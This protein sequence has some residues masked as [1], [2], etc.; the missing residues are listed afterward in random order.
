MFSS[1]AAGTYYPA[2]GDGSGS[3]TFSAAANFGQR[4]FA[5]TPPAGFKSLNTYNLPDSTIEDGGQYFNT[6]T[7]TG[8]GSTQS[9]T[10][11][12]FQ[13][14]WVWAK[15]RSTAN[16]HVLVDAVR[17]NGYFLRSNTTDGDAAV[18]LLSS[19]DSD[20]FS[21]AGG[22]SAVNSSGGT[23]VAWNWK[24]N[25]SGVSNTDGSIT[26]TVS[27]N[28]TAG[29]SIVTYTTLASIAGTVGHGL[30][31]VPDM[32]IAKSRTSSAAWNVWHKDILISQRLRLD[33]TSA[34]TSSTVWN[35]TLPTADVFTQNISSTVQDAVAY[36][37]A[38]VEGFSKFGSYTGNG[39]TDGPFIH[40]GFRPAWVMFKRTD[41]TGSWRVQDAARNTYNYVNKF[42][43]ANTSDAEGTAAGDFL[44]FTSNGIKLRATAT[45]WNA[46]GGTYIYMAFA[47]SPFKLSLAR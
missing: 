46:S 21:I 29:F 4:P 9:I 31:V 40:L 33:D 34:A 23:Y 8:N 19:F 43:N 14:D 11:V 3:A 32:V 38:D 28:T 12:G 35:S 44:D 20:G 36:C 27:A 26:S 22:Y 1:I 42:L 25:G 5:Y 24:A 30:G 16:Y 10:G 39:S 7:Y 15:S 41:S 17:G 2:I 13:P 18:A 6:V 37:F 45:D 47:E